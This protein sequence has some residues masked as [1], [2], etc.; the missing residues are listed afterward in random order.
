MARRLCR[1]GVGDRDTF[2][3]VGLHEIGLDQGCRID[4]IG[5][6]RGRCAVDEAFE[7]AP[8]QGAL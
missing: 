8:V 2:V 5:I 4:G 1:E 7:N 3:L 6:E